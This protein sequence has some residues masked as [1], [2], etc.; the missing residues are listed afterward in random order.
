MFNKIANDLKNLS[1]LYSNDKETSTSNYGSLFYLKCQS[2]H[3][4][5][6]PQS[7]HYNDMSYLLTASITAADAVSLTFSALS[8]TKDLDQ[9]SK[10]CTE[11]NHKH[12]DGRLSYFIFALK[13]FLWT[14]EFQKNFWTLGCF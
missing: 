14:L 4:Q 2:H 13:I 5:S 11:G 6:S 12:Q 1:R 3:L 9:P 8:S 10:S 7:F